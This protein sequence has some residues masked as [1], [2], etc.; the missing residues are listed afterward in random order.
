MKTVC[1]EFKDQWALYDKDFEEEAVLYNYKY[2]RVGIDNVQEVIYNND[3]LIIN[4][5]PNKRAKTTLTKRFQTVSI[6][7]MTIN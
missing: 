1:I 2:N 4:Y 3:I 6:K 7:D 5:K